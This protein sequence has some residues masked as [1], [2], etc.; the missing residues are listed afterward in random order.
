M[1]SAALQG[2]TVLAPEVVDDGS[3]I[4]GPSF[5]DGLAAVPRSRIC[6]AAVSG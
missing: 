6:Q 3:G 4:A 1:T 2:M 5:A